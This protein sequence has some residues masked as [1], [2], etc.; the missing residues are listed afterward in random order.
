MRYFGI[1]CEKQYQEKDSNDLTFFILALLYSIITLIPLFLKESA[2][3]L[4]LIVY[5]EKTFFILD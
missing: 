1:I 5:I 4:K 2:Q 3:N